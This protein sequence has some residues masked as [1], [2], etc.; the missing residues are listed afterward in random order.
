MSSTRQPIVE[1]VPDQTALESLSQAHRPF[2]CRT[3]QPDLPVLTQNKTLHTN[4]R[5]ALG[6]G[7]CIGFFDTA[8]PDHVFVRAAVGDLDR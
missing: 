6:F 7:L 1:G 3:P 2:G 4:R 8:R 5:P